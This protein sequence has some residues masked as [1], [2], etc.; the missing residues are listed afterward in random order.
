MLLFCVDDVYVETAVV[1]CRRYLRETLT[2]SDDQDLK[3]LTAC[4][5]VLLAHIYLTVG[6]S[7]VS[8]LVGR[9]CTALTAVLD[10]LPD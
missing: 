2:I 1:F 8:M 5:L 3:R 6:N 9:F 10:L 7:E 4:A